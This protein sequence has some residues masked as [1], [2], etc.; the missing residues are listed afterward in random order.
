VPP[1]SDKSKYSLFPTAVTPASLPTY[2]SSTTTCI[3]TQPR[4]CHTNTTTARE[5]D[6]PPTIREGTDLMETERRRE[7]RSGSVIGWWNKWVRQNKRTHHHPPTNKNLRYSPSSL[8]Q[9]IF[10]KSWLLRFLNSWL[11]PA[12]SIC[13]HGRLMVPKSH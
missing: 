7:G 11:T 12:C 9:I 3:V 8:S 4:N 2:P 6:H 13:T 5:I 1:S 10:F